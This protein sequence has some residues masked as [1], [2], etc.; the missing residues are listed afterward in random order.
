MYAAITPPAIVAIP[1]III[2]HNSDFFIRGTYGFT[3]NADSVCP[4]KISPAAARLSTPDNRITR[5]ITHAHPN[6]TYCRIP[7]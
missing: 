3:N 4:R 1:P 5:F 6:T 2:V 7:K